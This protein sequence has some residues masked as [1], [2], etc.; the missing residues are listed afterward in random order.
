MNKLHFFNKSNFFFT[1]DQKSNIMHDINVISFA[2]MK[3]ILII[4]VI[5]EGLFILFNDIP[6]IIN[7]YSNVIWNDSR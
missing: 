7:P 4:F 5:V 6:Y 3:L 1:K 2:R